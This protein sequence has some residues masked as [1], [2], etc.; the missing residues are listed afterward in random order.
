[1][2]QCRCSGDCTLVITTD[3]PPSRNDWEPTYEEYGYLRGL[4]D[5][6]I[7]YV[8]Q[9]ADH[10][11]G[12]IIMAKNRKYEVCRAAI[13][14]R[15]YSHTDIKLYI[16]FDRNNK[17]KVLARF[18][19]ALTRNGNVPIHVKFNLK[20][21]YF[22]NLSQSAWRI[23]PAIITKIMPDA[24]SLCMFDDQDLEK[25]LPKGSFSTDQLQALKMIVSSSS[26]GPPCLITGPFGTGKS[27]LLAAAAYWLFH[28]SQDTMQSFRILVCT[29]QRESADNFFQL[30]QGLMSKEKD[31]TAFIVR[32]YGFH[33]RKLRRWYKTVN[34][35]KQYVETHY[36]SESDDIENYLIIM[37]CLT[38]LTLQRANF[39]PPNFFTHIFIDEG[40]QM[41]EVE[42]IAPLSMASENTK[43]VIAGDP[44]QVFI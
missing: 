18:K 43:I 40:A 33:N 2:F 24:Q 38:A 15:N 30:Y 11:E 1:M 27:H 10:R 20:N 4:S 7:A 23:P 19:H 28:N 34:Q 42:A 14:R 21:S 13:L 5:D 39:L 36:D 35:F 29:Q 44:W 31:A 6:Q 25:H 37:P 32:D 17:T 12:V 41:R 3:L 8:S 26:S 22:R 16:G 9:S